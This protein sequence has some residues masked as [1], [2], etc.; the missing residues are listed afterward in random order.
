M[1]SL[2]ALPCA[3]HSG[4]KWHEAVN[5]VKPACTHPTHSHI[6]IPHTPPTNPHTPCSPSPQLAEELLAAEDEKVSGARL[7][8]IIEVGGW[9]AWLVHGERRLPCGL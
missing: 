7:V 6:H 4:T 2:C 5:G 9:S 8:E 3:L 1:A